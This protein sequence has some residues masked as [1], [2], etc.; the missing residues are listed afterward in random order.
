MTMSCED[1]RNLA[2]LSACGEA[3][4]AEAAVVREHAAKCAACAS[5]IRS[6]NE[7]LELLKH[8]PREEPSME[9]RAGLG[10]ILLREAPRPAPQSVRGWAIAAAA[11]MAITAT[12]MAWKLGAW[13]GARPSDIARGTPKKVVEPA[14][15]PTHEPVKEPVKEPVREP[16][17]K[18]PAT[19]TVASLSTSFDDDDFDTLLED[20]KDLG[21]ST[22]SVVSRPDPKAVWY[23]QGNTAVDSMY[24]S[25]ETITASPD[26]F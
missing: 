5:E 24:D 21:G 7:G 11:L 17:R 23:G 1:I 19:I 4:E 14:P 18:A 22:A 9:A 6:L 12:A 25:L 3:G 2:L 15:V 16:V 26:K 20:F 10:S 13:G 8:A